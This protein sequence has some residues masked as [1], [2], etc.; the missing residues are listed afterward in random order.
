M[1]DSVEDDQVVFQTDYAKNYMATLQ[2]EIKSAHWR[3]QTDHVIYSLCLDKER[4]CISHA[5]VGDK[6]THDKYSVFAC[7]KLITQEL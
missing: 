1:K 2:D 4:G 7:F 6:K 3:S 5:V